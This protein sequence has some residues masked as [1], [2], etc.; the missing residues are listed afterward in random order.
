M[1][2]LIKIS[3]ERGDKYRLDAFYGLAEALVELALQVG[4]LFYDVNW[5]ISYDPCADDS[6][7]GE[8]DGVNGTADILQRIARLKP[9]EIQDSVQPAEFVDRLVIVLEAAHTIRNMVL[10]PDNATFMADFLP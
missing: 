1:F 6:E 9:K 5:T 3:H 10:L 4:S 2:H 8:L 7:I